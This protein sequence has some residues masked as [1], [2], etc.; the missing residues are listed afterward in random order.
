MSVNRAS[1]SDGY[2]K[3]HVGL[4][5]LS[6]RNVSCLLEAEGPVVELDTTVLGSCISRKFSSRMS[7][8]SSSAALE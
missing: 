7:S 8:S 6:A 5:F 4:A 1:V 2:S 3:A